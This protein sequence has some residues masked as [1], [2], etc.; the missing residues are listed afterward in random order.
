MAHMIPSNDCPYTKC[1]TTPCNYTKSDELVLPKIKIKI[2]YHGRVFFFLL[3]DAI[4]K[5]FI[6]QLLPISP[7]FF[8][9]W[10]QQNVSRVLY[11]FTIFQAIIVQNKYNPI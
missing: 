3:L 10:L 1:K 9:L 6:R 7:F 4:S 11:V 5:Q 8:P 2:K